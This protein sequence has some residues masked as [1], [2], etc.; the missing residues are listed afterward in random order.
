MN[1]PLF[2]DEPPARPLP[3]LHALEDPSDTSDYMGI[4]TVKGQRDFRMSGIF[5]TQHQTGILRINIR[6]FQ[7]KPFI[8]QSDSV[9]LTGGNVTLSRIYP[10][11]GSLEN[12]RFHPRCFNA[13]HK[14]A[15]T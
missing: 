14:Q 6:A 5:A 9:H 4:M 8:R 2:A 7:H 11:E 13:D 12:M 15:G 10:N 1:M 3:R